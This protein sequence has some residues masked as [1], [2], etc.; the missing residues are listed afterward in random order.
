[1]DIKTTTEVS[2]NLEDV[3]AALLLFNFPN[4]KEFKDAKITPVY[5]TVAI[6]GADPHD[7]DYVDELIGV[8]LTYIK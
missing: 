1:M 5:K 6:P 3:K 8:K 7:C 2:F 4:E